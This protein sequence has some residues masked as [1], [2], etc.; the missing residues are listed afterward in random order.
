[1][2]ARLSVCRSRDSAR[3][4]LGGGRRLEDVEPAAGR[5]R[6]APPRPAPGGCDARRRVP[7][8]VRVS[9]PPGKS[10]AARP[11]RPGGRGARRPPVQTAGDHQVDDDEQLALEREDDALAQAP[12]P[13]HGPPL[14]RGHRRI[15]RAQDERARQAKPLERLPD[16]A[17][18]EGR[19]V[20]D[21]VG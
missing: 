7:A 15:D 8:S 4:E 6:R 1:M 13:H 11:T 18:L 16:D 21:D 9:V 14:D 12:E 5:G 17:R 20:R 10:N 2:S 19:Q 3:C